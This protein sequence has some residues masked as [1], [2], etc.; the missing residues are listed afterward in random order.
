MILACSLTQKPPR[1]LKDSLLGQTRW[2]D[3]GCGMPPVEMISNTTWGQPGRL[4]VCRGC[5]AGA[6]IS[7]GMFLQAMPGAT[8]S[9]DD[10]QHHPRV[11]ITR[12]VY[13]KETGSGSR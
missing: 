6:E 9:G 8:S 2:Q 13:T 4:A 5:E 1:R 11:Q 7:H 10:N 3:Q 12:N